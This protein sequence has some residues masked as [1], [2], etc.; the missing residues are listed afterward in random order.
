M[1]SPGVRKS[2]YFSPILLYPA[3]FAYQRATGLNQLER[4]FEE[5]M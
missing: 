2:S 5:R 3:R 4:V 1:K